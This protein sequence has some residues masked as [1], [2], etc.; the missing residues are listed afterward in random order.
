MPFARRNN[1]KTSLL[2]MGHGLIGRVGVD[3]PQVGS[4]WEFQVITWQSWSAVR[5]MMCT[6]V[7][8]HFLFV[9]A[10]AE[11]CLKALCMKL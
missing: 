4:G 10:R 5:S 2:P 3:D 7:Q 8:I 9:C 6:A 11:Q 1:C